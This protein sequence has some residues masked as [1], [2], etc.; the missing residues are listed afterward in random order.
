MAK[1]LGKALI[2]TALA[3]AAAAGGMA[4]Y[5][6]YK[7]STDDFDDDFLDFDDEDEDLDDDLDETAASEQ[8]ERGYV[9]IPRED[10]SESA[11]SDDYKVNV[12]VSIADN[13]S[14]DED[15]EDD[16]IEYV[17]EAKPV[18]NPAK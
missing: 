11:K 5:N 7:A 2:L 12:D 9:S 15:D 18:D 10:N 6:K 14:D 13:F 8:A 4:L 17:P 1:K 16:D 3:G